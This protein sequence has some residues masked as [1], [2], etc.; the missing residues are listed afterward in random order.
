MSGDT[1]EEME[2]VGVV[3]GIAFGG[4]G[5]I[6]SQ[7]PGGGLVVF[8]P[9]TAVGEK[10][11]FRI[12]Q[13]K[14]S[15]AQGELIEVLQKSPDRIS[16]LCPYFGT[17]GGCQ[18][19]HLKYSNQ[20]QIKQQILRDALERIGKLKN[21]DI[22]PIVPADNQWAYRR[23]IA[24]HLSPQEVQGYKVGYFGLDNVSLLDIKQCPIFIDHSC[25][26]LVTLQQ[27]A[28]RLDS[29]PGNEGRVSL[30][31][32]GLDAFIIHFQFGKCPS[33]FRSVMESVLKENTR[34]SGILG[35]F[36]NNTIAL[37]QIESN[38]QIGDLIFTYS[39]LAFIQNHPEQS[40]KIY[41]RIVGIAQEVNASK[42][43][44]LYCGIGISSIMLGATGISTVGVE[45]N[46]E[47]I[48]LAILNA[49]QNDMKKSEFLQGDAQS[50]V[51]KLIKEQKPELVLVNPPRQGLSVQMVKSLLEG[52][53]KH[54]VY[55]SC[56]PA[57]LA[58]DLKG[59]CE[60]RYKVI[61]C[62]PYDMFPQTTHLETIVN[63]KFY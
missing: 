37:G 1:M 6:R 62:Q 24:M 48:R 40:E 39:P 51:R 10:I 47:A 42:V 49:A 7:T 63:L 20:L 46:H 28:K 14:S 44:D 21:V 8:V 27:F 60:E 12:T 11:R 61:E 4:Q 29:I 52:R 55:V 25:D 31:K 56:M 32:N 3:S 50:L 26:L 30:F 34:I 18:F 45:Y 13:V 36:P 2:G 53:P 19:Q 59:L 9:F 16:P 5:I 41:R 38:L 57:T 22:L 23:H 17:C 35:S 15:F 58:R 43:M 33:N 54:I